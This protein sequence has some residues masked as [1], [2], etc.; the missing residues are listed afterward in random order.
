MKK[1]KC[2]FYTTPG[3]DSEKVTYGFNQITPR[4]LELLASGCHIIARY[5]D[6]ADSRYYEVG[7]F[8]KSIE[9][10]EQFES[11]LDYARNNDVDIRKYAEYLEKHYT[12]VRAKQIHQI[13]SQL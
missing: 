2:A 9:N 13:L 3:I 5:V 10:Y 8:C 1:A 6:N 12:S 4:F 7:S 11:S